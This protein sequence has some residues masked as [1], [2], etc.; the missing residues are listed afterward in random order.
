M[1]SVDSV[2]HECVLNIFEVAWWENLVIFPL[3]VLRD[4]GK[5]FFPINYFLSIRVFLGKM[6]IFSYSYLGLRSLTGSKESVLGTNAV[7]NLLLFTTI[8]RPHCIFASFFY[9]AI[10]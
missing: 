10:F 3:S 1:T 2:I 9:K 7:L 4:A 8:V 5:S 6:P